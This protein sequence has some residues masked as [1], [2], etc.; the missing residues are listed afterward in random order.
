MFGNKNSGIVVIERT[1]INSFSIVATFSKSGLIAEVEDMKLY[2]EALQSII[3]G[4]VRNMIL[5]N[6]NPDSEFRELKKLCIN[7][8]WNHQEKGSFLWRE[9]NCNYDIIRKYIDNTK[10]KKY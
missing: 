5:G 3:P 8:H 7:L 4:E 9:S 10:C 6:K 1:K 2:N